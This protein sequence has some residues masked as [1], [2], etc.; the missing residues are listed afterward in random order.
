MDDLADILIDEIYTEIQAGKDFFR[1]IPV[2][3]PNRSIERYLSL[4]F[5]HRHDVTAQIEFLPLMSVFR[6]FMPRNPAR[7]RLNIDEK[8]IGWRVYRIL[9]E[10]GSE[11]AFPELIRW[12]NGDAKKLYELSRQ[13][14]GLY[15]KYILY[16]P[17]WINEWEAGRMPSGLEREPAALWQG[18]LWRR[19]A[20]E[21]WKGG[22]FAAVYGKIM[23]GE[24]EM[25]S[26][27]DKAGTISI[28]G[29]SQLPPAVLRCLER[30]SSGGT[31]VTLYH[32]VP[33]KTFSWRM[34]AGKRTS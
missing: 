2:I 18:E 7:G 6:R 30:F 22:H 13:L 8:T 33:G 1:R 26:D 29:F 24:P 21:D 11:T 23:R 4:R 32:L 12:V 10:R 5:A 20:G 25:A 34:S 9:L 19:V 27:A 17:E 28:F 3:V 31:P 14:G 16:R 15:D